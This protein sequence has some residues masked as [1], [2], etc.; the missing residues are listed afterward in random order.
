M[1]TYL[2]LHHL[3]VLNNPYKT[4]YY[5]YTQKYIVINR[6]LGPTPLVGGF[7]IIMHIHMKGHCDNLLRSVNFHISISFS[8][9]PYEAPTLKNA[10]K[11]KGYQLILYRHFCMFISCKCSHVKYKAALIILYVS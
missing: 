3:V 1:P 11:M 10:F 4:I 2:I 5:K 9:R 8:H 6:G 7:Q